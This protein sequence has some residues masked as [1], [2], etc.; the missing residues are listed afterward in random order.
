ML[1][2]VYIRSPVIF[3]I[4]PNNI[5]AQ[6]L[7]QF[8]IGISEF[9]R[10][11]HAHFLLCIADI[12]LTGEKGIVECAV[13]CKNPRLFRP[14]TNY[15]IGILR[16]SHLLA[17][18]WASRPMLIWDLFGCSPMVDVSL[19]FSKG[20]IAWKSGFVDRR[21]GILSKFCLFARMEKRT[22]LPRCVLLVWNYA[23]PTV[24][25]RLA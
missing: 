14:G 3:T 22:V 5:V 21:S 4:F 24:I 17:H 23:T 12:I 25:S 16:G 7:C 18:T 10:N 20:I 11:V 13:K 6:Q 2:F 19:F 8:Y 9:F 1:D 15:F